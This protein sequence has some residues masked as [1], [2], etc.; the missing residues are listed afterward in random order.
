MATRKTRKKPT[1]K[2]APP[3][4]PP[5]TSAGYKIDNNVVKPK[6]AG[7]GRSPERETVEKLKVGQSFAVKLALRRRLRD[8]CYAVKK[9][10]GKT[11]SVVTIDTD[12]RVWRDK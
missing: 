4:A 3:K 12:V 9:A 5:T 7:T 1:T 6:Y 10:T 11:F 8:I 2:A